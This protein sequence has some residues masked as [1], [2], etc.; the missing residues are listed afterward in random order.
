MW[1]FSILKSSKIHFVIITGIDYYHV[2]ACNKGV[3]VFI[4]SYQSTGVIPTD[5]KKLDVDYLASGCLKWLIGGFGMS[6]LYI[7][8]DL[9]NSTNPSSIGW[10]GVDDPFADL[11]DKLRTTLHRPSNGTK[12]Q[13]G[14]PYPFGAITAKEGMK[15]VNNPEEFESL[16]QIASTEVEAAFG[17][18]SML[19][20][21][22][23]LAS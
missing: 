8:P 13:Y 10:M 21:K 18:G 16:F 5:V 7:R 14:T 4:D 2:R 23:L 15:I 9:I 20:E 1:I 22:Y 11:Y 12:F 19:I 17:D 6:F 3:P